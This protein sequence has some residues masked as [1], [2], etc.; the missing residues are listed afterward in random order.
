MAKEDGVD[1][2]RPRGRKRGGR[3]YLVRLNL[4]AGGMGSGIRRHVDWSLLNVLYCR[5]YLGGGWWI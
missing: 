1:G 5:S 2:K 4:G 3:G